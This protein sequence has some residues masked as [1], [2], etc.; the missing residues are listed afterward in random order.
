MKGNVLIKSNHH[1]FEIKRNVLHNHIFEN[2]IEVATSEGPWSMVRLDP[3]GQK[4][5]GQKQR[6]RVSWHIQT[7]FMLPWLVQA[8]HAKVHSTSKGIGK[9]WLESWFCKMCIHELYF[10]WKPESIFIC[11]FIWF[12]SSISAPFLSIAPFMA[13]DEARKLEKDRTGYFGGE[14]ARVAIGG[15]QPINAESWTS[16]WGLGRHF[17]I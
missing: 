9:P 3:F 17:I 6:D 8:L 13:E 1:E 10:K 16:K 5:I 11:F 15:P 7:W 4:I 12:V 2:H 14:R